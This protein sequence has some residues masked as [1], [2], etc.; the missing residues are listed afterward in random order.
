MLGWKVICMPFYGLM[1]PSSEKITPLNLNN[2]KMCTN[3]QP[4]N[5]SLPIKPSPDIRK[6][7]TSSPE[8]LYNYQSHHN[9]L[10]EVAIVSLN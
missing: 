7:S 3:H 8:P 5:P 4:Y 6:V 2:Q 10:M 9:Q 1:H